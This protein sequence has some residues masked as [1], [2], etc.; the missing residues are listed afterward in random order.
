MHKT[1]HRGDIRVGAALLAALL[2]AGGCSDS[3]SRRAGRAVREDVDKALRL[4]DQALTLLDNPVLEH[5]ETKELSPLLGKQYE[6]LNDE[7]KL[8]VLAADEKLNPKA[9]AKLDQAVSL[10]G[11]AI[12]R[13]ARAVA[14]GKL[15]SGL[16]A[17]AR[18]K[19]GEAQDMLSLLLSAKAD[20]Q[21]LEA[22][23]QQRDGVAAPA[24]LSLAFLQLGRA[25]ALKAYYWRV[26][27]ANSRAKAERILRKADLPD[28][29]MRASVGLRDYYVRL[30]GV[31][32]E[33]ANQRLADAA[34]TATNK[35][36]EIK[37]IVK[38]IGGL[39]DHKNGLTAE[40][41]RLVAE[42]RRLRLESRSPTC[43]DPEGVLKEVWKTLAQANRAASQIAETES[44]ID[45]LETNRT[46]LQLDLNL[47][48]A[49]QTAMKK[50][51]A[52]TN[53][54]IAQGEAELSKAEAA[55]V[56]AAEEVKDLAKQLD[57]ACL[58]ARGNELLA[59]EAFQS[60][61]H[62]RSLAHRFLTGDQAGE[63]AAEQ[64]DIHMRWAGFCMDRLRF[65]ERVGSFS[66]GAK[67]LW[68]KWDPSGGVP[69]IFGD[70]VANYL[71][72]P[73]EVKKQATQQYREAVKRYGDAVAKMRDE[74]ERL[75]AYEG[76]LATAYIALYRLDHQ[77]QDL[78][79]AK[80]ILG[81]ALTGKEDSPFLQ[82]LIWWQRQLQS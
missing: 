46:L 13:Q 56:T 63:A 65:R 49:V 68:A 2:L 71:S 3:E 6:R 70:V 41:N 38:E 14:D 59:E 19:G 23:K 61:V 27:A 20:V 55:L 64:G 50:A 54:R 12:M 75:W 31:S 72:T 22:A 10:L 36:A 15:A 34:T 67:Q 25:Y 5:V 66:Q 48:E 58:E 60:A 37:S 35:N 21:L 11:A 80:K 33:E 18:G 51:V 32:N 42:A 30:V 78:E 8:R 53:T 4:C 69:A 73:D 62:A 28:R 76:Q 79:E 26:S 81:K 44:K 16:D 77:P 43:K 17:A 52:D 82:S 39:N 1:R 40:M 29:T 57:A 74:R 45:V 7:K 24:D 9:L 47:A